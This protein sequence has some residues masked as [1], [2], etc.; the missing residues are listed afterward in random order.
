MK[1]FKS[2]ADKLIC[3]YTKQYR[4]HIIFVATRKADKSTIQMLRDTV[5]EAVF[6]GMD[7][8]PWP[9]SVPGRI[10]TACY[11]DILMATNDG[12]FLDDYRKAGV[13][14]CVFMPNLCDPDIEYRYPVGEK[15][16]TDILWTGKVQ[17][18]AGLNAD[19]TMR[20]YVIH[21]LAEDPRVNLYGCLGRPE[22]EGLDYLHAISGA[23]I[24][25]SVNAINS[26]PLYHSD[27]F[28]YYTACGTMV[29]AKRVPETE[30]LM[31]DKKHVVYFDTP[32][33]CAELAN[34]Y[35]AHE[36]ERKKI[37]DRGMERCH[38]CFNPVAMTGYMLELMETGQYTAPWGVFS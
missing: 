10:E 23:R 27:R 24:G 28:T 12:C 20:Q 11:L 38:A 19:D 25:I 8:D 31:E 9:G 13:K 1:F 32:Q 15:W 5:S 34:W 3:L 16:K 26:I 18:K 30:R 4:P 35:L 36:S 29:L 33:E 7:G 21:L 37:A 14:K 6:I 22:V 2:K 17:H